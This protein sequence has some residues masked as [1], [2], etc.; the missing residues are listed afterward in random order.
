MEEEKNVY[1]QNTLPKVCK[2]NIYIYILNV[3]YG[4]QSELKEYIYIYK[5][6]NQNKQVNKDSSQW[7]I[8]T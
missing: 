5:V 2:G 1:F 6:V 8:L 4:D 3:R 7:K